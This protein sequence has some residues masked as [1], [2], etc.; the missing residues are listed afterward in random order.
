MEGRSP[1]DCVRVGRGW[2]RAAAAN[3]KSRLKS[4]LAK[5]E[6]SAYAYTSD[7]GLQARAQ[8]RR[9]PHGVGGISTQYPVVVDDPA[10]LADRSASV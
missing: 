3:A 7:D 4:C 8:D 1:I 9:G 10:S 5:H 2:G 6:E